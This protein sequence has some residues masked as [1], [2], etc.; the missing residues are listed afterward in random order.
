VEPRS[1]YFGTSKLRNENLVLN[2]KF[3]QVI[4]ASFS[5]SVVK[6]AR[7]GEITDSCS[8]FYRQCE[9]ERVLPPG[10]IQLHVRACDLSPP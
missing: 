8:S 3:N 5:R 1:T 4:L 6:T 10:K 7:A 2:S 9:L